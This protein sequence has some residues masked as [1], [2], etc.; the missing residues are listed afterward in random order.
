MCPLRPATDC[1]LGEPLPHQQANR[2]RAPPPASEDFHLSVVCGISSAFAKLFPTGGQVT[3]V[4]L[5]RAPLYSHPEGCFLVRLACVRRAASVDS[6]PGSNSRLNHLEHKVA[7]DRTQ[8]SDE[9]TLCVQ[10]DFQTSVRYAEKFSCPNIPT[11]T[12]PETHLGR[13]QPQP[14]LTTGNSPPT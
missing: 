13:R 6:E 11:S 3:H 7:P 12:G 4:L 2:P 14:V 10:P 1:R 8:S 5:T 9:F